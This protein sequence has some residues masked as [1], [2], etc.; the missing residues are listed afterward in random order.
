MVIVMVILTEGNEPEE[1]VVAEDCTEVLAESAIIRL[2]SVERVIV[3]TALL[4][5]LNSGVLVADQVN[6]ETE[7]CRDNEGQHAWK[8]ERS[9]DEVG[10]LIVE[11]LWV[12]DSPGQDRV[13]CEHDE[14]VG[15]GAV[16]EHADEE[17][18]V[19]EPDT[20]CYPRAVMVHLKYALIA[21]IWAHALSEII[22][23]STRK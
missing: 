2:A 9:H 8:D 18:I 1:G 22:G 19:V 15:A 12:R 13:R 4:A 6:M 20:I 21:S 3:F 7:E 11:T 14:P 17:L 10:V 16:E 23:L 5:E